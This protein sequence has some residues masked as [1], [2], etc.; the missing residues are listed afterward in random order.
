M[1]RLLLLPGGDFCVPTCTA[2]AAGAVLAC[3]AT[4]RSMQTQWMFPLH[5]DLEVYV[6][7]SVTLKGRGWRPVD[8]SFLSPALLA[9]VVNAL[10]P[11]HLATVNRPPIWIQSFNAAQRPHPDLAA[12][13]TRLLSYHAQNQHKPMKLHTKWAR[14][15]TLRAKAFV[16]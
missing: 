9:F 3:A 11:Q 10:R 14:D 16:S 1:P 7:V 6:L 2:S 15:A 12:W 5:H 13:I 4:N 8:A